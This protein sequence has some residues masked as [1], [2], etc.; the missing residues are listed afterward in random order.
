MCSTLSYHPLS[1]ERCR[2][3]DPR[4]RTGRGGNPVPT[5]TGR[6]KNGGVEVEKVLPEDGVGTVS[7]TCPSE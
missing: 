1:S 3:P 7:G 4:V 2:F 5:D 6:V